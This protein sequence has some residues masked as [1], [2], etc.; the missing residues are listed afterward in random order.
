MSEVEVHGG[1]TEKSVCGEAYCSRHVNYDDGAMRIG[2]TD[3]AQIVIQ[4]GTPWSAPV[5]PAPASGLVS[6]QR[7]RTTPVRP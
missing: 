7:R 6:E 4:E 3:M 1:G 5:L 2:R